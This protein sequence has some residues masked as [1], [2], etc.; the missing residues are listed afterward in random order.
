MIIFV[1]RVKA[2]Q[3]IRVPD[4]A[5]DLISTLNLILSGEGLPPVAYN[6]GRWMIGGSILG[7]IE[8]ALKAEGHYPP[9][10]EIDRMFRAFVDYY[11]AHIAER[12]R[13]FP[14]VDSVRTSGVCS[15]E[16]A[17]EPPCR[18]NVAAAA[19][20]LEA[21]A[22]FYDAGCPAGISARR[23][24]RNRLS[25]RGAHGLGICDTRNTNDIA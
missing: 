17:S 3:G 22:R 21:F 6:D 4:T 11:G 12:S 2:W 20:R 23:H 1:F 7:M 8:R 5:P 15:T 19:V 13:P 18:V 25:G 16:R 24:K 14:H 9:K 10:P